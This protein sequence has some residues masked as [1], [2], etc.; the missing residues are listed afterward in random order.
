[1]DLNKDKILGTRNK[2]D[3][4]MVLLERRKGDLKKKGKR[5]ENLLTRISM[6]Q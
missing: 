5:K 4:M 6:I 2:S 1:M 3:T